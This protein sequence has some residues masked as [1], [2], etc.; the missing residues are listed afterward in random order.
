MYK[1][2][3]CVPNLKKKSEISS[4]LSPDKN[5][6]L[7]KINNRSNTFDFRKQQQI[8][9]NRIK[10]SLNNIKLSEKR[11]SNKTKPKINFFTVKKNL[12]IIPKIS[13][14]N[15]ESSCDNSK[16]F[17]KTSRTYRDKRLTFNSRIIKIK[18]IIN[19]E[20]ETFQNKGPHNSCCNMNYT[21]TIDVS[22]NKKIENIKIRIN[23][24]K[25]KNYEQVINDYGNIV[26]NDIILNKLEKPDPR[27]DFIH[28]NK[29]NQSRPQTSY[30]DLNVRRK[31]LQSAKCNNIHITLKN[32][33]E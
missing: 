23:T 17:N 12:P 31:N 13:L 4:N 7:V 15:Y 3:L 22:K 1:I 18:S 9:N 16:E 26:N 20:N 11:K 21:K 19:N 6:F 33:H 28:I 14:T 30:G 29:I 24:G 10:I 27:I 25:K 32:I 2:K 8:T 5:S